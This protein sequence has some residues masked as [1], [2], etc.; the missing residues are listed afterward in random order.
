MEIHYMIFKFRVLSKTHVIEAESAG[1]A[2]EWMNRNVIDALNLHPMAWMDTGKINE[3]Y[4]SQ[5]NYF[6]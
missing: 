3:Y 2:M 4:C 5:G 1:E 6:D